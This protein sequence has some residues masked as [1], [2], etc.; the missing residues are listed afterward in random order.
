M[1]IVALAPFPFHDAEFGGGERIDNL[2]SRVD[3][4]LRVYV[5]NY[6]GEGRLQYKNMDIS[7]HR[8]PDE[9]RDKDYDL[10]VIN[11]SKTMFRD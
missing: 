4:E 6:G 11:S 9:L 7:F 5:P 8:I 10:S 3:N 2:L 1:R